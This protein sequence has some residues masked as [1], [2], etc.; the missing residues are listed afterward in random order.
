ML[1][2]QRDTSRV[3]IEGNAEWI[4]EIVVHIDIL[5]YPLALILQ[6][7]NSRFTFKVWL[8]AYGLWT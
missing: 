1:F 8:M 4:C 7:W 2:L 6:D 3:V 5:V